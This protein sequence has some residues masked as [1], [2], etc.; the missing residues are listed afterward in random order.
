M[1]FALI[2]KNMG[3]EG[4]NPP[5]WENY[6]ERKIIGENFNLELPKNLD[7]I[8]VLQRK[9]K[10]YKQRL[11]EQLKKEGV[12]RIQDAIHTP[13]LLDTFYKMKLTDRLLTEGEIRPDIWDDLENEYGAVSGPD[14]DNAYVVIEDYVKTGGR[15]VT[16]GT[17]LK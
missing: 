8:G 11:K 15:K 10:E 13:R 6:S 16:G 3:N 17:G 5:G 1:E 12:T 4:P 9:F 14:L 2:Y 7:A